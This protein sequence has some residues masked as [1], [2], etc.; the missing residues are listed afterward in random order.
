[1]VRIALRVEAGAFAE[2]HTNSNEPSCNQAVVMKVDAERLA[3][4][5]WSCARFRMPLMTARS[6]LSA[7][8]RGYDQVRP[9]IVGCC[10]R[11]SALRVRHGLE[12]HDVHGVSLVRQ[13]VGGQRPACPERVDGGSD[14]PESWDPE[15]RKPSPEEQLA[16]LRSIAGRF[17]G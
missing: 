12:R 16:Q 1:M 10:V 3:S 8:P 13:V 14:P 2:P 6:T 9:R 4:W 5:S 7:T 15:P 17:G 11:Q